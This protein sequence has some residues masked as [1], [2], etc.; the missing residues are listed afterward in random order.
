MAKGIR[1]GTIWTLDSVD[2]LTGQQELQEQDEG[3]LII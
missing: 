2:L 1:E 3:F